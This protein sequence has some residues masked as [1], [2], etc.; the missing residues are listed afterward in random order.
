[1]SITQRFLAVLK[2][3]TTGRNPI[4]D[5]HH[6]GW[7]D[8]TARAQAATVKYMQELS[9]CVHSMS[10]CET[11]QLIGVQ[12][13][14]AQSYTIDCKPPVAAGAAA[15]AAGVKG[16]QQIFVDWPLSIQ[17]LPRDVKRPCEYCLARNDTR[18]MS[19]AT[20]H[21]SHCYL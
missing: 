17:Q 6:N 14:F 12:R 16:H 21:I 18:K 1:M 8:F 15:T 2:V 3:A 5:L 13:F 11:K 19:T 4:G 7:T 9:N 10:C 20:R